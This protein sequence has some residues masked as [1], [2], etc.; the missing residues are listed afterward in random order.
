MSEVIRCHKVKKG[1]LL[2]CITVLLQVLG[3]NS[4]RQ[5]MCPS[6]CDFCCE[7]CKLRSM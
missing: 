4:V 1:G 2:L 3:F 5:C 6:M 7:H